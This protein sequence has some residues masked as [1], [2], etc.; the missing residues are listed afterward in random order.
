MHFYAVFMQVLREFD[1]DDGGFPMSTAS[2]KIHQRKTKAGKGERE[3]KVEVVYFHFI[4]WA[5]F[6]F[7]EENKFP[8]N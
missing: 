5:F 6:C 1:H 2:T 3:K 4:I 7:N 8:R